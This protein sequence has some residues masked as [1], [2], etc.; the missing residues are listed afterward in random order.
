MQ[1]PCRKHL[2]KQDIM[3]ITREL[4]ETPKIAKIHQRSLKCA[5][6]HSGRPANQQ[7]HP[8]VLRTTK[9][10]GGQSA[11]CTKQH[12]K[13]SAR[14]SVSQDSKKTTRSNDD[15]QKAVRLKGHYEK[16]PKVLRTTNGWQDQMLTVLPNR[17]QQGSTPYHQKAI[18]QMIGFT[19]QTHTTHNTG[20]PDVRQEQQG[21]SA[22]DRASRTTMGI[23]GAEPSTQSTYIQ[24][25]FSSLRKTSRHPRL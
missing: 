19:I 6:R 13:Y 22:P 12:T 5:N 20:C 23:T 15:Q 25:K 16:Q 8:G 4:L 21:I 11:Q 17:E 9:S 10:T 3:R 7:A 2:Q 18:T 1:P 14:P 24:Y